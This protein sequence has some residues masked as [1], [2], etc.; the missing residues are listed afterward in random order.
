MFVDYNLFKHEF[1][2]I[3]GIDLNSYKEQ[4]MQRRILQWITRYD[5][6]GFS[7]LITFLKK[8]HDHLSN[9]LDYLTINT[10]HF[11]RDQS[12]FSEIESKVLPAISN[13]NSPSI[14]SAGCSIGA[15]IYSIVMLLKN[16]GIEA[17]Q[18]LA[19][20]IDET[21]LEKAQAGIFSK[22]QVNLVPSD[23]LKKY[24]IITE[25]GEYR[26]SDNV[27]KMVY[28]KKH[29]LLKDHYKRGFDLIMCRNVF[30]Y[31]TSEIQK[32]LTIKFIDSLNNDGYF[33]VGS[34]EQIM[35][36]SQYG[37]TRVS[38]CIYQKTVT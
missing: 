37:L 22:N 3:V 10:S 26:I 21:V 31:F 9:F 16:L 30:I 34:A 29:N 11:F 15:E 19:T 1:N 27:K 23:L 18:Y 4:Q 12:V 5:H 17:K 14:W 24:F 36:P 25:N 35:N 38:Y 6:D 13:N 8:D 32:E 2:N 28:F 33:I 20:D 7:G